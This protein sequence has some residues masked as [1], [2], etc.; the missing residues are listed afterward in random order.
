MSE[1]S[2]RESRTE[3]SVSVE[4]LTRVERMVA[5]VAGL[6]SLGA[7]AVA[8][9]ETSNQAGTA[10]LL[11]V[12]AILLILAVHG[13][14][15]IGAKMSGWEVSMAT[16]RKE[17]VEQVKLEEPAE[18]QRKLDVLELLDPS[19]RYAPEVL[20]AY[21]TLYRKE[22]DA[23]LTKAV[24]TV[25][26]AELTATNNAAGTTDLR[27][28]AP[29][30]V[31]DVEIASSYWDRT[32]LGTHSLR[33]TYGAASR[34]GVRRLLV[35]NMRIPNEVAEIAHEYDPTHQLVQVA[36]WRDPQD[37]VSLALALSRLGLPIQ[38]P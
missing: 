9:F 20:D 3:P 10:V 15:L 34:S 36:R 31:I 6:G 37:D 33:F 26:N 27:V 28:E 30:L 12:G 14:P 5:G 35:T 17:F 18:G 23:A 2:S 11:G 4:P 8:V 13:M 1:D 29:G 19:S 22:L 24:A 16:R 38:A 25:P 7:G 21:A 32:V